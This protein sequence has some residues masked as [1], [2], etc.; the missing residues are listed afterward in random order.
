VAACE[1]LGFAAGGAALH[2]DDLPVAE[3]EDLKALLASSIRSEPLRRADDLVVTDL[4]EL[5]LN[6]GPSIAALLDLE[7]QDLTGLVWTVSA[8]RP[9]PPQMTVR[10]APPFVLVGDQRSEGLWVT[11]IERFSCS[12]KLIDHGSS[13]PGRLTS[14]GARTDG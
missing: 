5:G 11:L 3:C 2:V 1:A 14:S 10:N 4:D 7:L 8:R 13:M 12:S 9:F 6:L